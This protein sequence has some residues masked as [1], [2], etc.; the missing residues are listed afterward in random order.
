MESTDRTAPKKGSLY[1][2]RQ[3]I[4]NPSFQWKYTIT[5][6]LMVFVIT[7]IMSIVLYGVLHQQARMRAMNPTTYHAEVGLVVLGSAVAFSALTAAA[8]GFWG[9]IATHR[10]CG[11]LFVV[12]R[13]LDELTK[14]TIPTV[15]P[16]RQKDEFTEFY[17]TFTGAMAALQA[18]QRSELSAINETL[19]IARSAVNA[20][21]AARRQAVASLADRIEALRDAVANGGEVEPAGAKGTPAVERDQTLV[22]AAH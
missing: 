12:G 22:G 15:R 17:A 1:R 2:R 19:E 4:I 8:I 18:R 7:S 11:P 9:I 6:A 14:G 13:Y 3:L 16:L 20:D 10:I 21:D 5:V